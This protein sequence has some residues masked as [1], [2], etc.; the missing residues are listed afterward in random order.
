MAAIDAQTPSFE[1]LSAYYDGELSEVESQQVL[2]S[3][4]TRIHLH[5][6]RVVTGE[7]QALPEYQPSMGFLDNLLQTIS[8]T[9]TF[10]ELS[11]YY[12]GEN[13]EAEASVS[14]AEAQIHLHNMRVVTGE[15]Q[16]LPE[17]QPSMGFL[18]NLLQ[19]INNTPTFAELSAYYD[20]ENPEAEASV[21]GAEAQ[22]H[23]HN[24][25]VVTGELQALP[26][27]QPSMGFLDN[28]L[29]TIN[30]TP[31]FAELSAYYDGENPEAEAS[32][33]GAEAQIHLHNMKVVTGEL[34]ALPEYQPSADFLARLTRELDINTSPQ[35]VFALPQVAWLKNYGR[36]VAG[37]AMFG[38]LAIAG[39]YFMNTQGTTTAQVPTEYIVE[40]EN[41]SEDAIF[42]EDLVG[43]IET[44]SDDGYNQLIGG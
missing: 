21:S 12:D 8:S 20:G 4:H 24:M 11:A 9:P 42:S 15:L 13:P 14:G 1:T 5:N 19:T 36:M 31:T 40:L 38:L 10:A 7:L 43:S 29:Q 22:I 37:V 23:L 32:V 39:N 30:S 26:E 2:A 16:A 17:Y 28:L 35:K 6:M 34:Q 44:V 3:S 27:Y 33:S 18:D 25:R 41:Q